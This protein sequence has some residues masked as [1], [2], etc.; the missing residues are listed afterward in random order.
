M[1][2]ILW[3]NNTFTIRSPDKLSLGSEEVKAHS[4]TSDFSYVRLRFYMSPESGKDYLKRLDEQYELAQRTLPRLPKD[5]FERVKRESARKELGIESFL[6]DFAI[7]AETRRRNLER[8]VS[9]RAITP[10]SVEHATAIISALPAYTLA[11][12]E[13]MGAMRVEHARE[14]RI[15]IVVEDILSEIASRLPRRIDAYRYYQD[16]AHETLDIPGL[17]EVKVTM[18]ETG[19]GIFRTIGT[20]EG[21]QFRIWNCRDS[22]VRYMDRYNDISRPQE[23]KIKPAG[24]DMDLYDDGS[25]FV[26]YKGERFT[27]VRWR[28]AVGRRYD[29]DE[30]R[31]D[32]HRTYSGLNDMATPDEGYVSN[33]GWED[34]K[35]VHSWRKIEEE[36]IAWLAE[37]VLNPLREAPKPEVQA[38]KLPEEE[39]FPTD[40]IGPLY[41]F[42]DE[43]ALRRIALIKNNPGKAYPDER[44]AVGPGKRLL[45][46]GM[47]RGDAPGLVYDGYVW[48]GVGTIGENTDLNGIKEI[49][50]EYRWDDSPFHSQGVAVIK[51]KTATD[52][53]VIDWQKWDDYRDRTF[54]PTHNRLT[55]AEYA[56]MHRV[57]ARTI[58]PIT[59]YRGNYR[60]PIVLIGRDVELDEVEAVYLPPEERRRR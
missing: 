20:V 7:E 47:P 53:Y 51:P 15:D 25:I 45:S 58:V 18:R 22:G 35:T 6:M 13:A 12:P 32:L 17:G 33:K 5:E 4:L 40:K 11:N 29:S 38:T 3:M 57:V 23:I 19:D 46:L 59:E 36:A 21:G 10:A 39:P 24:I 16:Y 43:E 52:V 30:Y 28:T 55:D 1:L 50:L 41:A 34:D 8:W 56:E 49:G 26:G 54:T 37:N 60:K 27:N 44:K 48:C 14:L 9:G 42:V 2:L 31:D